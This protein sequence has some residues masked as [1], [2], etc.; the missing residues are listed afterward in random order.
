M[1]LLLY[2]LFKFLMNFVIINVFFK[3]IYYS[4]IKLGH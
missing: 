4:S 1:N 3:K 2:E